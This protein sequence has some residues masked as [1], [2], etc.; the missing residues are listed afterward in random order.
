MSS[1]LK[2]TY[3]GTIEYDLTDASLSSEH[4]SHQLIRSDIVATEVTLKTDTGEGG[5]ENVSPEDTEILAKGT[6]SPTAFT[7][8]A[9]GIFIEQEAFN[10]AER[11]YRRAEALMAESNPSRDLAAVKLR[12]GCAFVLSSMALLAPILDTKRDLLLFWSGWK[13]AK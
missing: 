9:T 3:D 11:L 5:V 1:L 4:H 8:I 7:P 10:G 13:L 2:L 12:Q 6:A